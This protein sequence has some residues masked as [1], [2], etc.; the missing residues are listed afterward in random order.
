[1]SREAVEAAILDA[2]R[3]GAKVRVH[4]DMV[5]VQGT[6]RGITIQMWVNRATG[7]LEPADPVP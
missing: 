6:S 5:L 4:G 1:M 2:Y 7:T 3:H